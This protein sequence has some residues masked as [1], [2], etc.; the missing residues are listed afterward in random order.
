M[1]REILVQ[2]SKKVSNFLV[3]YL[4]IKCLKNSVDVI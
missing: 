3:K 4:V 1:S 2:D